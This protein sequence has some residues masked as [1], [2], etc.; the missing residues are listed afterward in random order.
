ML[1]GCRMG[2]LA[3]GASDNKLAKVVVAEAAASTTA[4]QK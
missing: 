1:E 2:G 3:A 4:V